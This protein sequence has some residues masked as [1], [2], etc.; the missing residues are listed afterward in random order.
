MTHLLGK[1]T[2]DCRGKYIYFFGFPL[3]Y[4]TYENKLT[5][6]RSFPKYHDTRQRFLFVECFFPTLGKELLCLVF[7]SDTR[8]KASLLS[9]FFTLGK[10]NFKIKFWSSKLIQIKKFSTTQFLTHQDA[11]IFILAIF[12]MTKS[13]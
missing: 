8:Q 10:Y 5:S 2:C 3:V 13:K 4:Y 1:Q 6:Y 9:V 11:Q 7:F 12:H